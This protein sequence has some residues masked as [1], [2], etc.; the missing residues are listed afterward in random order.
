MPDLKVLL[1]TANPSLAD[2]AGRAFGSAFIPC[3]TVNSP[4]K[5]Q[6]GDKRNYCLV[7]L[8]LDCL[9]ISKMFELKSFLSRMIGLPVIA[10][11][12]MSKT[13]NRETVDILATGVNDL[14]PNA[15]DMNLLIA[16][17][18]AHLRR[19]GIG[20]SATDRAAKNLNSSS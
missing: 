19:L 17:T 12:N 8:D 6:V 20:G 9:G 10:M 15:I 11:C 7:L 2:A 14:M 3:A 18:R 4:A 13:S 5:V 1:I 16:K